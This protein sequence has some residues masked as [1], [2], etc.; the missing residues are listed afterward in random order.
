MSSLLRALGSRQGIDGASIKCEEDLGLDLEEA[1]FK[2]RGLGT[3]A[4]ELTATAIEEM[5]THYDFPEEHWRRIRANNL[6]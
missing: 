5:L 6:L 2:L 3:R 4:A 1:K